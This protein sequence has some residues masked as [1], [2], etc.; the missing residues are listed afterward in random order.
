MTASGSET[1]FVTVKGIDP[2]REPQVTD[3]ANAMRSGSLG[4]L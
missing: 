1:S 4:A 3:I 2:A